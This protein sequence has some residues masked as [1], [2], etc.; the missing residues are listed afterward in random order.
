MEAPNFSTAQD[1]PTNSIW[2]TRPAFE[3][4]SQ[5]DCAEFVF[6]GSLQSIF[7]HR[8]KRDLIG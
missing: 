8:D 5:V 4:I 1:Q 7:A 2:I 6:I 3:P